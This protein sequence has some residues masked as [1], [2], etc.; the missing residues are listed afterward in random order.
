MEL[1]PDHPV[2]RGVH[3]QWHKIVVLLMRKFGRTTVE[4]SK[5]EI[6]SFID[7][8]DG[9]GAVALRMKERSIEINLVSREE[10]ERLAREE[11]GMPS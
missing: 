3:D 8:T 4:I 7:T 5:E 6:E 11:G 9:F 2:T 1:N 10:A